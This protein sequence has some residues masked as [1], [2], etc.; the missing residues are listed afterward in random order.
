MHAIAY[1][2]Y[3]SENFKKLLLLQSA[4]ECLKLFLNLLISAVL[5]K[6]LFGI[7]L[8]LNIIK[9]FDLWYWNC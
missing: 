7:F 8:I 1:A 6:L 2:S 5:T 9:Y 4:Y 3:R